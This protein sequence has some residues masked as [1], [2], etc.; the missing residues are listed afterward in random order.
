M[1]IGDKVNKI[2][3]IEVVHLMCCLKTV[4]PHSH[5]PLYE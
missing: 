2:V 4:L 5:V 1:S 3:L